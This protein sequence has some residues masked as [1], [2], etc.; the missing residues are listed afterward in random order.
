MFTYFNTLEGHRNH[1]AILSFIVLNGKGLPLGIS[2]PWVGVYLTCSFQPHRP[3]LVHVPLAFQLSLPGLPPFQ[4]PVYNPRPA[5]LLSVCW[6]CEGQVPA[7]LCQI[8]LPFRCN[9]KSN[10]C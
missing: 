2:C 9:K 5:I 4:V 8:F 6:V 3:L 7:H 10:S 1:A